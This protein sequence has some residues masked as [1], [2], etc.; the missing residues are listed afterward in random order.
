MTTEKLLEIR[1][2][3]IL[4][5]NS[6]KTKEKY[7]PLSDMIKENRITFQ[8]KKLFIL[9]GDLKHFYVI[10][11]KSSNGD[12]KFFLCISLASQSSDFLV[13]LARPIIKEQ[14]N[15][16]LLQFSIF[17]KHMRVNLLCLKEIKVEE[18]ISEDIDMLKQ[19]RKK[20]LKSL[21]KLLS[22]IDNG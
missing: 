15:L 13:R 16:R 3:E 19:V 11:A 4:L 2:K 7:P 6:V 14:L 9:S 18:E 5:K 10:N 22:Q 1:I 12:I 17:P 20:F 21:E 8:I